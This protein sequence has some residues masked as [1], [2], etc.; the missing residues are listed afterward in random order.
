MTFSFVLHLVLSTPTPQDKIAPAVPCTMDLTNGMASSEVPEVPPG[1]PDVMNDPAFDTNSK[2]KQK[3]VDEPDTCRICRGEGSQEER[4]FYP[5][6]CSGSI[7]FVHQNCLMEWLSHSQKKHCELCKTPFRFTKLYHPH[8]PNKV[9]LLVFLRQAAIHSWKS[10][11]TWSRFH[12]VLFV[13]VAWLPWCMRTVFRGLFWIGDGGWI[14]WQETQRQSLLAAQEH[15]EKLAKEGTTPANQGFFQSRDAAASAVVSHM[16]KALPHIFLPVAA[17]RNVSEPSILRL[18]RSFFQG[19]ISR[20]SSEAFPRD[21]AIN[22]TVISVPSYRIS[23]LSNIRF[24]KS[25]TP[26]STLN[27]ILIDT[28]EGQLIT[29]SVVISFILI[30]LIREWVVQQQPGMNMGAGVEADAAVAGQ[31]EEVP[32]LQQLAR[33]HAEQRLRR[34]GGQGE[35]PAGGDN[36]AAHIPEPHRRARA[37][38]RPRPR[39]VREALGN[40]DRN[41]QDRANLTV[42]ESD[43]EAEL[44]VSLTPESIEVSEGT[45]SGSTS[46]LASP[47]QQR[48]G[49]PAKDTLDRVAEIRRTIDEQSQASGDSNWPGVKVFKELWERAETEPS[50][51]LKIIEEEGRNDELSWIVAAMKRLESASSMDGSYN[52]SLGEADAVSDGQD[53]LERSVEQATNQSNATHED[54]LTVSSGAVNTANV[55]ASKGKDID[56]PDL[57]TCHPEGNK[58]TA[59]GHAL[60]PPSLKR[61]KQAPIATPDSS[62][63]NVSLAT[64]PDTAERSHCPREQNRNFNHNPSGDETP[65]ASNSNNHFNPHYVEHESLNPTEALAGSDELNQLIA[66][67]TGREETPDGLQAEQGDL[68]VQATRNEVAPDTRALPQGLLD[69][70][71]DWLWG[72]LT[73]GLERTEQARE[74]DEHVVDDLA[75]EAPFVPVEHGQPVIEDANNAANPGQDPEVVAAAVQAGLDPN[76]AEAIE[77]GEDLEG[78]MELVG[79]QGPMAGLI[80]NGMFCAVLVS[81][82]IF[83][84]MWIPYIAGKVFLVFLANPVSLLIKLPL[85]WTSTSADLIIDMC[86]FSAGLAYYWVDTVVRFLCAPIGW[87]VPFLGKLNENK[88]LADFA[89]SYAESALERLA[90]TFIETGGSLSESD[91]PTFSILAHES[92]RDIQ[93]RSI[94][95]IRLSCDTSV[96]VAAAISAGNFSFA[97]LYELLCME[98]A[99]CVKTY[100]SLAIAWSR[101]LQA[102]IPSLLKINPLRISLSI[103]QRTKPLDLSLV[104]WGT[105]DRVLAI[106]S[107]YIFF[108]LIGVLYLKISAYLRGTKADGKV[109]GPL[110]DVLYQAGGVMKVILII[111]IEM[112]VFPLY[113]G[114]LLDLALLPLFGSVT[115]VSRLDFT[116]TSPWTSIF[117][118][119]FVGT[120][121]MFHFAL[122]VS[123]C[124]KIMRTGVLCK[125]SSAPLKSNANVSMQTL[126]AILTTLLSTLYVTFLSAAFPPSSE[127]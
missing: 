5:C 105:K 85:R 37:I 81:L 82:T 92:L 23:W 26:S 47:Y 55:R 43:V 35:M 98:I 127:R 96:A 53:D 71:M 12:L 72:G 29:T 90:E 54:F 3:S 99:A 89:K 76:E 30:F 88:L 10:F 18:A 124:R 17:S 61:E 125:P 120:C 112:I 16:A 46:G 97:G 95:L 73:P 68:A 59:P 107:G 57:S 11:L 121:Y 48:P 115:V 69:K 114:L 113:C 83:F 79:M 33:Q 28:L 117:V 27:N 64:E 70:V 41:P 42:P 34:G 108:S 44:P 111:S 24:L 110:A 91:I 21:A 63:E 14:N 122:F 62:W 38:A 77:D 39:R 49:M 116:L 94:E 52:P 13:W 84:G 109:Q 7:K 36:E 22:A 6:K 1:A 15:L 40:N 126:F 93:H 75:D 119:W 80:Q 123:M 2:G 51:V 8:M 74:D 32:R 87:A 66:N 9:P 67:I 78:I 100:T 118:H 19:V 20:S 50:E 104:Y 56:E 86:V 25:L 45:S 4:L 65:D 102:L 103:P 101:E 31:G 58:T 60:T 106:A